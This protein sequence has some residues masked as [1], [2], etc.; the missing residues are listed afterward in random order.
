MSDGPSALTA[1]E[2]IVRRYFRGPHLSMAQAARVV[3]RSAHGLLLWVPIG[4]G[5]A[6][7]RCPDGSPMREEP[8]DRVAE[9]PLVTTSWRDRDVLML[10]P[11]GRA[12]SVWWFFDRGRFEGWYVNLERPAVGW[13]A[14]TTAGLDTVDHTLDLLVAPDGT[15]R[16]KDEDEFHWATGRPGYWSA[17]EA[18]AVRAEGRRLRRA[19]AAG[20][21]PF[22]GTWCDVR[23][24]SLAPPMLDGELWR[25]RPAAWTLAAA[26]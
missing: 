20:R 16:W 1:G 3:R 26:A 18:R 17:D 14:G 5:F 12:H 11:P 13:A 15:S 10:V 19:A 9:A 4:S 2:V 21:F 7:L 6:S 22:D 24:D 8:I 25:L 23:V